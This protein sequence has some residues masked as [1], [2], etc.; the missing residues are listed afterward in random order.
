M[1]P[2]DEAVNIGKVLSGELRA[3]GILSAENLREVGWEAALQRLAE[4]NPN[5][6]CVNAAL[7]L[8]GAIAGVRWM[9]MP[10]EERR[11]VSEIARTLKLSGTSPQS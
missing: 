1:T 9:R 10:A 8:A 11:R 7:A 5:R 6:D 2:I 4:V 3:V